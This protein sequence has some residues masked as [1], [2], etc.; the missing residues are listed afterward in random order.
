MPGTVIPCML[1]HMTGVYG[2]AHM[3]AETQ[4][5]CFDLRSFQQKQHKDSPKVFFFQAKNAWYKLCNNLYVSLNI[6]NEKLSIIKSPFLDPS[7]LLSARWQLQNVSTT[8]I[9]LPLHT[10]PHTDALPHICIH[11]QQALTSTSIQHPCPAHSFDFMQSRLHGW[12][13]V[14]L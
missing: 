14:S 13:P 5:S 2:K 3:L 1:L 10:R 6:K 9:H 12:G 7:A 8:H 4:A 11:T